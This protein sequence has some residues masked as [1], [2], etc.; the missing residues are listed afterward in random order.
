[1]WKRA[2]RYVTPVVAVSLAIS[3]GCAAKA[4]GGPPIPEASQPTTG[5]TSVEAALSALKSR[6][7]VTFSTQGGWIIVADPSGPTL[8][9]F[10]PKGHAAYPSA[11]KRQIENGPD[12]VYVNMSVRCEAS[13]VACDD[14]VRSFQ[15]L[16]EQMARSLKG[17]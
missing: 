9:S 7:D 2:F 10:A 15:A 11:V 5:Y 6:H 16:N 17:H 4:E 14:L 13:K 1:M 3:L 12:G 8:W